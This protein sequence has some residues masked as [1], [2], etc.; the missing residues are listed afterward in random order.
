MKGGR[1]H[2]C[3]SIF[4]LFSCRIACA[5]VVAMLICVTATAKQAH[6]YPRAK[7]CDDISALLG[8]PTIRQLKSAYGTACHA[9]PE[10]MAL[11][12]RM[13]ELNAPGTDQA[14]LRA[15]PRT[16]DEYFRAWLI[17]SGEAYE[18]N[19]SD[20]PATKPRHRNS[21]HSHKGMNLSQYWWNLLIPVV[22][23]H[24]R[25]MPKAIALYEFFG[26]ENPPVD[27]AEGFP[28]L[29]RRLY[30]SNPS[31]F[32]SS[33]KKSPWGKQALLDA[34]TTDDEEW[35]LTPQQVTKIL[36]TRRCGEYGLRGK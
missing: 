36:A 7:R 23:R 8:A 3:L 34:M 22:A 15:I 26:N 31:A 6:T 19:Q 35:D 2:M 17:D 20:S 29:I 16:Y 25:Y 1:W 24:P 14:I 33:L 27:E 10:R 28:G 11:A 18:H 30:R 13:K 9:A 12:I 21:R 5:S 32:C 4:A